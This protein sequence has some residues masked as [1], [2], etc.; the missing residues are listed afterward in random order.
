M[1]ISWCEIS[2]DFSCHF[3]TVT[4]FQIGLEIK[5]SFNNPH[6]L[7]VL[8]VAESNWIPEKG[9]AEHAHDDYYHLF[10]VRSG[11]LDFTVDG[12]PY[13]LENNGLV[14]A[15]PGQ[16]HSMT[17]NTA[18]VSRIYEIKFAS[19]SPVLKRQLSSIP[20]AMTVD[21]M[22]MNLVREIVAEGNRQ[23]IQS[24]EYTAS[25]LLS[26]INYLYRHYG[27]TQ[28]SETVII[29]T[30][31]FSDVCVEIVKFLESN[32]TRDVS[33]Q[34]VADHV[35][36]NKNY[37]CTLFKRESGMTIGACHTTIRVR[38]AAEM[39]SFSDMGIEQVA[40]ATGFSNTSHF[41]R[42]FKKV[43]GIPPGQYR[44][45][46]P[47]KIIL[48]ETDEEKANAMKDELRKNNGFIVAVLGRKKLSTQAI[49]NDL[50]KGIEE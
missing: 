40:Y 22:G 18:N 33:L 39:I 49:I 19:K 6:D 27:I 12:T 34:E 7:S 28:S 9:I 37:I 3:S 15:A 36:F 30:T 45:M 43:A 41:N 2:S 31:G 16:L 13:S 50:E 46:Y 29:D 47:V 35:G 14:L 11:A 23:E 20:R 44:R 26:L 25:Y 4:I 32:W 42:I 8:W 38:K 17:N 5:M 24:A 10:I 48:T 1:I 21:S